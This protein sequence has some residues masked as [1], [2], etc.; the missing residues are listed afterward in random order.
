[1]P[2]RSRGRRGAG[3]D[4]ERTMSRINLRLPER[5]KAR[6]EQAAASEGLSVNAWLV[7]AAAAALERATRSVERERRAPARRAAL[8]GL[9]ALTRDSTEKDEWT[10]AHLRH[11]RTDLRHAGARRRRRPG[12][13]ERSHRHGR[14][15]AAERPCE[16]G[17]RGRRR[18]DPR[19]V[20]ER[21]PA[22]QGAEGMATVDAVGRQRVDRRARSSCRR[23]R[24]CAAT[25]ASR[26][27]LHRTHR[28]VPVQDAAS[29]TSRSTETGPLE[30]KAGAGDVTV[31]G[32][33]ATAEIK[34]APAPSGSAA[35]DGTAAIKNSNGDTWIGEVTG[36]ARVN[37]A[38]GAIAVDR[39]ARGVDR[40]D[41]QR[42]RPP[43]RG[44]ARLVV[45]Q[46]AFGAI[47][48]GV[49]DGVAAWLDLEHEVRPRAQRPGRADGR[50]R[51]RTPSRSTPTP[52]WATS[53]STAR[54]A[55]GTGEDES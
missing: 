48:V 36:D 20:R 6:V 41:R 5:L 2:G 9:G 13:R 43:R 33:P 17:R 44:R 22:G 3:E 51:T 45:A 24:R 19:R 53:R 42:Q 27:S 1:M 12:R 11:T 31:D 39:R 52:R 25:P 49:R 28:R 34:T 26:P 16:E 23:A 35:I 50:G 47:E 54:S 37:A 38:N 14:R 7:R 55:S 40:Q 32:S 46:S 4:D 18:A 15:R 8:H 30:L 29:A 21:H 10:D